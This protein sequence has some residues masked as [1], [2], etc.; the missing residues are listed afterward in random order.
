M[1]TFY[2]IEYAE[3]R[4]II[5][6]IV[7]RALQLKKAAVVAVADPYGELIGLRP[8]GWRSRLFCPHRCQQ[9]MDR[10]L[11]TQT[12]PP[13]TSG[14]RRA[15]P[16]KA[17]TS[18]IMAT[19]GL[20]VGAVG[21]PVWRDGQVVGAVAVSGLSSAEDIDLAALGAKLVSGE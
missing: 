2:T 16:K 13:K 20:W 17:L 4:K 21:L 10:C 3:A 19:P 5:E 8:H 9:S 6:V 1:K 11:R 18:R 15:V 14:R 12:H 7:E